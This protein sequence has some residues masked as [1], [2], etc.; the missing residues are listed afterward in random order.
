MLLV[1]YEYLCNVFILMFVGKV[2][3]LYVVVV[4]GVNGEFCVLVGVVELV[5]LLGMLVGSKVVLVLCFEKMMCNVDG[6]GCCEGCV[7]ECFFF[8]N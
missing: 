4:F 3:L 8:G 7:I 6:I 1:V 2:N 5:L